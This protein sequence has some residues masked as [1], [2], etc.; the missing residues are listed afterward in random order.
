LVNQ[1]ANYGQLLEYGAI[2]PISFSSSPIQM[3]IQTRRIMNQYSK[4][5]IIN[6]IREGVEIFDP[7]KPTCLHTDWS[8]KKEKH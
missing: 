8:Q 1:V 6:A 3:D 4:T 2:P 7:D 5:A